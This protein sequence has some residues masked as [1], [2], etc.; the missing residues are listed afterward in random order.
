MSQ[1]EPFSRPPQRPRFF[2]VPFWPVESGVM[3]KGISVPKNQR[4]FWVQFLLFCSFYPPA[5]PL[6]APTSVR[7][8]DLPGERVRGGVRGGLT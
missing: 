3:P 5:V 2:D 7:L 8:A 1:A 6:A 4:D